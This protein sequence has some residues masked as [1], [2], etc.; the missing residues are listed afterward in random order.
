MRLGRGA[1]RRALGGAAQLGVRGP[2]PPA[3]PR[4]ARLQTRLGLEV[5]RGV[6][7]LGASPVEVDGGGG[8]G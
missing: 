6:H 1:R 8:L 3:P 4:S 7:A 2:D 5:E